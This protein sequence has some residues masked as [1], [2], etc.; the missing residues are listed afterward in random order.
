MAE[1][2]APDGAPTFFA[3]VVTS[4][5]FPDELVIEFRRVLQEH[6]VVFDPKSTGIQPV[7]PL[8]VEAIYAIPPVAR[9]VLTFS[10]AQSLRDYLNSTIPT[11]EKQRA[12]K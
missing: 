9:V 8:P 11:M 4:N 3:N 7:K 2:A 6:K 12:P 10:A 5:L 1:Y